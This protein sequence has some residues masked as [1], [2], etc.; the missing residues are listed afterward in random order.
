MRSFSNLEIRF[1]FLFFLRLWEISRQSNWQWR[2]VNCRDWGGIVRLNV[3]VSKFR[4]ENITALKAGTLNAI[5]RIFNQRQISSSRKKNW[6]SKSNLEM[7][8]IRGSQ[9]NLTVF[10]RYC[11]WNSLLPDMGGNPH[12]AIYH[13]KSI[14]PH[15]GFQDHFLSFSNQ[16]STLILFEKS[17][18]AKCIRPKILVVSTTQRIF[19][20]FKNFF[21]HPHVWRSFVK[22]A[23]L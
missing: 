22:G 21:L 4:F 2:S 1:R 3:P 7:G 16:N 14:L 23:L 18:C 19:L 6:K 5:W 20:T 13:N 17:C 12:K 9:S 15:N 10:P 11:N 8:E